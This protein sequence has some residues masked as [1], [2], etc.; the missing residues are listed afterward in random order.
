MVLNVLCL[1]ASGS[2]KGHA[3][4]MCDEYQCIPII[5]RIHDVAN[6]YRILRTNVSQHHKSMLRHCH[7]QLSI[8]LGVIFKEKSKKRDILAS[9]KMSIWLKSLLILW[10]HCSEIKP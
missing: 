7:Y 5:M 8:R 4:G 2:Y 6:Y 1:H 10:G 3:F 9:S